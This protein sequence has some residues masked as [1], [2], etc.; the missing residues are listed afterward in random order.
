M[1]VVRYDACPVGLCSAWEF[2]RGQRNEESDR[3]VES[4]RAQ[5]DEE[6]KEEVLQDQGLGLQD[7]CVRERLC[8]RGVVRRRGGEGQLLNA[9]PRQVYVEEQK[10]DAEA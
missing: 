7:R 4:E 5:H 2:G 1:R 6:Q 9:R 8:G 3:E 10:Q